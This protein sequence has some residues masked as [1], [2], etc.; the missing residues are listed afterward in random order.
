LVQGQATGQ[1]ITIKTAAD[2]LEVTTKTVQ[3][4][5]AK[6]LLTRVKEGTR[7]LLLLAEV[8]DLKS[9][10]NAGQG[11]SHKT[12]G[13]TAGTGQVGD[14]VTLSRERYEQLL[15]E[16]GELRKQNQFFMEFKGIL[17]A[18]EEAMHRLER[19]VE[20]LRARV[21]ALELWNPEELSASLREDSKGPSP[22]HEKSKTKPK[23][24]W[25]QA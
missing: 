6:G 23:K 18:K 5:L 15:L 13:K 11:Q 19:D 9:D 10:A 25:W 20:A 17:L 21:R 4:Y 2:L 14:T 12:P 3:R 22:I 7:T 24:P 1:K 16:L 8:K